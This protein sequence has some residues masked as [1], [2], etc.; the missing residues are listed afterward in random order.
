[1]VA[2][3]TSGMGARLRVSETSLVARV[4]IRP[5]LVKVGPDS[6]APP[7]ETLAGRLSPA[8]APSYGSSILVREPLVMGEP[9]IHARA[10]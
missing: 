6:V 8:V 1:M 10:P 4:V 3:L 7:R 5:R 9:L 2:L